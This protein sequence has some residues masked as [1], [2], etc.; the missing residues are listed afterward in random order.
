M[1]LHRRFRGRV[2]RFQSTQLCQEQLIEQLDFLPQS[3]GRVGQ[4]A[5]E[6]RGDIQL[7][8]AGAVTLGASKATVGSKLKSLAD[9]SVFPT[10]C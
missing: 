8:E 1:G 4:A 6:T 3:R 2:S 9:C 5:A 7:Q 10:S